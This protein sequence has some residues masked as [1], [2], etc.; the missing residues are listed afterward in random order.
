[1]GNKESMI[2]VVDTTELTVSSITKNEDGDIL[3][4]TSG[5]EEWSSET[6]EY[7]H[8][9]YILSRLC[10]NFDEI[11]KKI[12]AENNYKFT[13][14]IV[15]CNRYILYVFD[16]SNRNLT[17]MVKGFIRIVERPGILRYDTSPYELNYYEI[18]TGSDTPRRI[19]IHK[20]KINDM[21]HDTTYDLVCDK[22][23][24][25]NYLKVVSYSKCVSLVNNI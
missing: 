11:S 3:I 24:A 10:Q 2:T 12:I 17:I 14:Q 9:G 25:S 21:M 1:M 20:S 7:L 19:I 16:A 5:Y 23:Y 6:G 15:D 4:N 13:Y 22:A 18:I 8:D